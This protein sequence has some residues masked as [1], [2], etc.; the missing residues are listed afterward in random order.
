[1]KQEWW[2]SDEGYASGVRAAR[3]NAVALAKEEARLRRLESKWD[4]SL[5]LA[6][7][8]A[9]GIAALVGGC[10]AIAALLRNQSTLGV[11]VWGS[12]GVL[13]ASAALWDRFLRDRVKP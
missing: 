2:M 6:M 3:V 8:I 9:V 1:M 7:T 4:D 13:V 12:V 11:A 5:T 10:F